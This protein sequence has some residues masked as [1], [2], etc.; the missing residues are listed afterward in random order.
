L[1]ALCRDAATHRFDPCNCT[2]R[3]EAVL[4]AFEVGDG[5][6]EDV[7]EDVHVNDRADF[8]FL[9]RVG[10]FARGPLVVVAQF[11]EMG[12]DLVRHLGA[13]SAGSAAKRPPL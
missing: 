6:L 8:G 9:V 13:S 12:A 1:A 7:A 10:H 2:G 11:L 4:R 5:L 3:C